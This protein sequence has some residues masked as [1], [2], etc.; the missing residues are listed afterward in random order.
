M[1]K[2][3]QIWGVFGVC[4]LVVLLSMVWL[5]LRAVALDRAEARA[6]HEADQ[7]RSRAELQERVA[8]ALWRMDWTLAPLIAQEITRPSYSYRP[9]LATKDAKA[10]KGRRADL[11][12]PLLTQPSRFVMLN[13]DVAQG[14]EWASPQSPPPADVPHA[15]EAGVSPATLESNGRRLDELSKSVT[16]EQLLAYVPDTLLPSNNAF[17]MSGYYINP[18]ETPRDAAVSRPEVN[19]AS[20]PISTPDQRAPTQI[21][22]PQTEQDQAQQVPTWQAQATESAWLQIAAEQSAGERPPD[23]PPAVSVQTDVRPGQKFRSKIP[24]AEREQ[25]EWERRNLGVQNVARSQREQ[26]MSNSVFLPEL[27]SVQEGTSRPIW[28]DHRLVV[29]RRVV[30][31]GAVRIQGCW[32]DWPSIKELLQREVADLFPVIDLLP[33]TDTTTVAPGRMLATLPVQLSLPSTAWA[34]PP[35]GVAEASASLSAIRISLVIAWGCLI[36]G[37]GASAVMLHSVLALSERRAA[38]VSAVTH[39]LRSPLTTFRMYAEMLAEGMV[40][41]DQQRR[42]YLETLRVEADRLSH[43]VDNVLQYARLERGQGK[44]RSVAIELG[45]LMRQSTERLPA[46]ARQSG[47]TLQET[48]S[49]A[50]HQQLVW[51]DPAAIEQILFNLVDNACKYAASATDRRIHIQW[52]VGHRVAQVRVSDHGPGI[53]MEQARKLFRPFSKTD[54]EAAQSA[55]G[56]GLGLALCQRLARDVGGKLLYV[57]GPG[58]GAAFLL[59]LPLAPARTDSR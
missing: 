11:A 7:A 33:V 15:L 40:R 14:G 51:T 54:Q 46:R 6:R 20:P 29:A 52:S 45:R 3:W 39:E 1:K 30:A 57:P 37:C 9:F 48:L 4:L 26:I 49:P 56:I 25:Q 58:P 8:L 47:M 24:L 16:F 23:V 31:D 27:N 17:G 53:T 42:L 13:F 35:E 21:Q 44:R 18:S 38:F 50:D 5:T 32:L 36:L 28:I 41:D 55:P 43:L 2:P 22:Q 59:E 19:S 12:S 34:G 10:A